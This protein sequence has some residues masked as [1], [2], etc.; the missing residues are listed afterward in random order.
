LFSIIKS[1]YQATP[2]QQQKYSVT[3]SLKINNKPAGDL[4]QRFLPLERGV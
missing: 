2:R 4:Q 3:L 1:G